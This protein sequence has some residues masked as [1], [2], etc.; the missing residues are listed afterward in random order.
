MQLPWTLCEA[1]TKKG[2]CRVFGNG[3]LMF[4]R[5]LGIVAGDL[6]MLEL[7]MRAVFFGS[8]GKTETS[9][10]NPIFAN[11]TA[12]RRSHN[13]GCLATIAII[14]FTY[15]EHRHQLGRLYA[16]SLYRFLPHASKI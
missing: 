5:L 14:P 6:F 10:H 2:R 16:E 11:K 8:A 1:M 4:S 13:L 15:V 7:T 3:P 9:E 12:G